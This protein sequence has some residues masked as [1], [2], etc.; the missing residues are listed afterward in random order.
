MA[1][2]TYIARQHLRCCYDYI[3]TISPNNKTILSQGSVDRNQIAPK[4]IPSLNDRN[5]PFWVWYRL[6]SHGNEKIEEGTNIK[7]EMR[8]LVRTETTDL[9]VTG[10]VQ[11][12]KEANLHLFRYFTRRQLHVCTSPQHLTGKWS[13]CAP[14]HIM[15][16]KIR[17][18]E[19]EI[20]KKALNKG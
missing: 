1:F 11:G 12:A 17:Q 8:H 3:S 2:C 6:H 4:H 5:K 7:R 18:T 19:G 16:I 20:R 14:H 10:T 13:G 9:T 15:A